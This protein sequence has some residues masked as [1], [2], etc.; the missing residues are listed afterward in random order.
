MSTAKLFKNGHILLIQNLRD[1]EIKARN[2]GC[3]NKDDNCIILSR[4][5]KTGC[6]AQ[7]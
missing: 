1:V 4:Y 2:E 6:P 3:I 5:L 7:N